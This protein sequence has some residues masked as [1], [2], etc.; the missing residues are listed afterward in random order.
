MAAFVCSE[1][2]CAVTNPSTYR[3]LEYFALC[4][5]THRRFFAW[6]LSR[7]AAV[8]SQ[9]ERATVKCEIKCFMQYP[10][11]SLLN[12]KSLAEDTEHAS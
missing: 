6:C 10:G 5:H 2:Y 8:N 4:A 12:R 9:G 7:G 3:R 11:F 1:I